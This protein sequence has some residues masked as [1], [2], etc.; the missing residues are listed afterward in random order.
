MHLGDPVAP[1]PSPRPA[2]V[3]ADAPM[4]EDFNVAVD[5]YRRHLIL[6]A[7]SAH[8]GNWSAAARDLG[9]DR[10]NLHRLGRRLGIK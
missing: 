5:E 9:L 4:P 7:L 6:R 10:S 2:S 1:R 3:D 8:A